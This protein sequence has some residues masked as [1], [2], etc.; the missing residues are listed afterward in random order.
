MIIRHDAIAKKLRRQSLLACEAEFDKPTPSP[1]VQ[2]M[3]SELLASRADCETPQRLQGIAEAA[4][5]GLRPQSDFHSW[6]RDRFAVGMHRIIRTEEIERCVRSKIRIRAE[7][8]WETD[9]RYEASMVGT[10]L[11]KACDQTVDSLRRTP[12]GCEWL[13]ERWAMLAYAAEANENTWT[14][15]QNTMAFDLLKTPKAFR[16]G[17]PGVVID[18]NGRV[19]SDDAVSPFTSPVKVGVMAG[20]APP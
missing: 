2:A 15:E 14:E 1:Q 5:V 18:M 10:M 3:I 17:Q 19:V 4:S 8:C 20:D 13:M 6:F 12:Q 11:S 7:L 9:R 16:T